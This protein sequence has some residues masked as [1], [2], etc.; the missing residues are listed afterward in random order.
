MH[1]DCYN[2]GYKEMH[3]LDEFSPGEMIAGQPEF[4]E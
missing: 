2:N 3:W 4:A 1:S